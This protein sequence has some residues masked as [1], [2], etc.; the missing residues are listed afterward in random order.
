MD[1]LSNVKQRFKLKVYLSSG[2]KE[3]NQPFIKNIDSH[4]HKTEITKSYLYA[5]FTS[6]QCQ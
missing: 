4:C 2:T 1:Q 3:L 5:K 6:C